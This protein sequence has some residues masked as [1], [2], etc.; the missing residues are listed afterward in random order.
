[1]F[2]SISSSFQKFPLAE[3]GGILCVPPS[4][5]S[6]LSTSVAA[7]FLIHIIFAYVSIIN[8]KIDEDLRVPSLPGLRIKVPVYPQVC[9]YYLS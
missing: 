1:M 8:G 3:N 5:S 6:G 9:I 2:H 4:L 7:C